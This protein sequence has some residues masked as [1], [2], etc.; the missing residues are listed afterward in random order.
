M[1]LLENNYL[2]VTDP[3]DLETVINSKDR[4]LALV[5]ATWCPFCRRF[6][7]VFAKYAQGREDFL[8][9]QDDEEIVADAYR[10]DSIPSVLF[11]EYGKLAK[12]LDGQLGIGLKEREL[13]AF[14]ERCALA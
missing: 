7:P 4:L 1:Q 10:V 13:S 8:F 5:F 12:R 6:L 14:I 9:V 2:I 11:F 3:F